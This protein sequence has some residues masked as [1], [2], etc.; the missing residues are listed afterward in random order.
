[1]NSFAR[2]IIASTVGIC[3]AMV[4]HALFLPSTATAQVTLQQCDQIQDRTRRQRCRSAVYD[5]QRYD[6]ESRGWREE[7][8]RIRSDHERACRRVGKVA[9]IVGQGRNFRVVCEA[10][11]RIYDSRR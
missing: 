1:M 2:T 7:E 11:R 6:E 5:A 9:R 10:P 8:A 3:S 4:A